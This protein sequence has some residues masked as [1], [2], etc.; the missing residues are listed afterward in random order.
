MVQGYIK[1]YDKVLAS[2]KSHPLCLK[3]KESRHHY[4]CIFTENVG[5]VDGLRLEIGTSKA[6]TLTELHNRL[7]DM[8]QKNNIKFQCV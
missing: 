3:L 6:R 4:I 7:E 8:Y 5:G 2:V 1:Q